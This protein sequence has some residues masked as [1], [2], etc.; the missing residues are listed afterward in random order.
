MD[1]IPLERDRERHRMSSSPQA[2]GH[3]VTAGLIVS[4]AL[5]AQSNYEALS[6][7]AALEMAERTPERLH[8][9]ARCAAYAVYRADAQAWQIH[10]DLLGEFI[11]FP[12]RYSSVETA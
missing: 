4:A 7:P 2:V 12:Q 6:E 1:W 3:A 11:P 5:A 8:V 9:Q 10:L